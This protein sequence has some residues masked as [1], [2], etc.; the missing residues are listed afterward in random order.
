MLP[1]RPL[2]PELP[3]AFTVAEAHRLGVGRGRL[4]GSD[5]ERP[6]HGVRARGTTGVST[7]DPAD[8]L[9]TDLRRLAQAYATRMQPLEFFS[10]RTAAT[11][12][13]IPLPALSDVVLDVSVPRPG[14]AP[15]SVGVRGH[16]AHPRLVRVTDHNGF[17]LSSPAST[18]A[19]LGPMLHPY[20]LVAAGDAIVC[21][22]AS[23]GGNGFSRAPLATV[24][25]L[26]A[27]VDAGRR[28]GV[29]ALQDALGRI[30]P[31]SWSRLETW[32]RLILVDAGL[33]EPALNYDAYDDAGN[34]LGCIDLAYPELKIA[35]EYEGAH[36][37]RTAEQFHRDIDRL[38]RLVEAG[39]RIVRL[40]GS[41]V[42]STPSEVVRRVTVA[43]AQCGATA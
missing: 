26:R 21:R 4:R 37:W 5:L 27:A 43:R 23:A 13:E 6:F 18:W 32:V 10:H 38:N 16:Q 35:I 34:F 42:F 12:W 14:R 39:W 19:S 22:R 8:D 2:P 20:D 24:D 30:R 3:A 33:P 17:K 41:H 25:Q 1:H 11:L 9:R 31:G 40:T 29:G 28:P 15:R 36:H 7:S